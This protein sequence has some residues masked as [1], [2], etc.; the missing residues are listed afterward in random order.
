M[1][2]VNL[3]VYHLEVKHNNAMYLRK[4]FLKE[5]N[6]VTYAIRHEHLLPVYTKLLEKK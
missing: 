6:E 5:E 3:L 4:K 2:S 1:S